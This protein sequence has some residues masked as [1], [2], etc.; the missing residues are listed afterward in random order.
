[1]HHWKHIVEPNEGHVMRYDE[2]HHCMH[3]APDDVIIPFIRGDGIGVDIMPVALKVVNA[4]V[5]Q[6]YH[7]TKRIV[8]LE[9][10]AAM[11]LSNVMDPQNG[12]PKKP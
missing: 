2:L 8:W 12:Y 4:A 7:Q 9:I 3:A 10:Y 1:M 6:A 11:Q 5:E